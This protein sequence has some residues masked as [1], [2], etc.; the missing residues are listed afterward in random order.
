V[1]VV[2]LVVLVV[3]LVVLVVEL[4][5][6][7]VELVLVVGLVVVVTPHAG[8]VGSVHEQFPVLQSFTTDF[9]HR[10]RSPSLKPAHAAAI[11]SE[12]TCGLHSRVAAAGE[13]KT[14]TPNA[15]GTNM[16]TPRLVIVII[17]S[18]P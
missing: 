16:T 14:P 9:L 4:V 18:S 12:Q 11:C 10:A 15:T 17:E 8:S 5:A 2:G 7:V 1:L 3:G 13:T 6:V